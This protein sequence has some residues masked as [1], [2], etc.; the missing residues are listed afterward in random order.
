MQN[1]VTI[2]LSLILPFLALMPVSENQTI[3]SEPSQSAG[4]NES[5]IQLIEELEK[6]LAAKGWDSLEIVEGEADSISR[7]GGLLIQPAQIESNSILYTIIGQ[8]EGMWDNHISVVVRVVLNQETNVWK[9]QEVFYV[10]MG[11]RELNQDELASDEILPAD[12][13]GLWSYMY[14]Y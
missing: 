10:S 11:G 5:S 8:T 9:R 2:L 7:W 1:I 14:S 12:D 3:D 4:I 13:P 6:E